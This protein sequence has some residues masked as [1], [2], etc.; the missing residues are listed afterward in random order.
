MINK[1]S[2]ALLILLIAFSFVPA[3]SHAQGIELDYSGWV[4]C[5]GVV[6]KVDKAEAKRNVPCNFANLVN[7]AGFLINWLFVISIPVIVGLIAYAG[8]LYMTGTQENIKKAK[9]VITNAVIG[10]IIMLMAWFI[11]TTLLK[12]LLKP[13]FTGVDALI[14]IQK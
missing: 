6:D 5:D 13:T 7:M 1:L 10:F 4:Q 3:I 14:Q 2:K 8:F 11:V 9:A 12:W